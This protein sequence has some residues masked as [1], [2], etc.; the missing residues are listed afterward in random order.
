MEFGTI[1][2]SFL[3]LVVGFFSALILQSV[4]AAQ[5][6]VFLIALL[7]VLLDEKLTSKLNMQ[8]SRVIR[9]TLLVT[10]FL[11]GSAVNIPA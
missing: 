8:E 4:N 2:L 5:D 10:G 1:V 7:I 3:F 6:F 11:I 9:V